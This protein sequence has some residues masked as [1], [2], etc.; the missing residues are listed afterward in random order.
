MEW[1]PFMEVW[2]KRYSGQ[3]DPLDSYWLK[4]VTP[5]KN[6]LIAERIVYIC[7]NYLLSSTKYL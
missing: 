5:K 7:E 2:N 1:Y 3:P 6:P 4:R